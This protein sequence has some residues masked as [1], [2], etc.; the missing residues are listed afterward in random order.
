M[1]QASASTWRLYAGM[2]GK[3]SNGETTFLLQFP[4]WWAYAASFV[5]AVAASIVG[6]Y[7][8]IARVLDVVTGRSHLPNSEG[9]HH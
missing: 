5:A 2:E 4:V 1:L 6:I 8:A 7:C 9:A 3:M